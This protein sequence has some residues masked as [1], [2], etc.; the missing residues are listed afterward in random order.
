MDAFS[1][2]GHRLARGFAGPD[3]NA[4]SVITAPSRRDHAITRPGPADDDDRPSWSPSGASIA[5]QRYLGA[6]QDWFVFTVRIDGSH[7]RR[8][9]RGERPQWSTRGRI[10][11][12]RSRDNGAHS[13]IY[14]MDEVGHHVRRL[15]YGLRDANPDWSP[16]GR[17]LAFDR[18]EDIYTVAADGGQLHRLTSGPRFDFTPAFSPDGTQIVFATG[19][20]LMIIPANGGRA[21]AFRCAHSGCTSPDWLPATLSSAELPRTG[22]TVGVAVLCGVG[23]LVVGL[24]GRALT[25][26]P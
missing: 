25:S 16:D 21:R 15:T 12:M 19:R 8:L 14:S 9:A 10:A 5:F 24:V 20:D 4:L 26:Q 22:A 23:A 17:R 1:P 3:A 7:L 13:S 11:F 6:E 2:D 18:H